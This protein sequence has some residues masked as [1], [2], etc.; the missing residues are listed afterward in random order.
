M[1]EKEGRTIDDLYWSG[2]TK[3][4]ETNLEKVESSNI[5]EKN[6]EHIKNFCIGLLSKC[7]NNNKKPTSKKRAAKLIIQLLTI[8]EILKEDLNELNIAHLERLMYEINSNDKW[9]NATKCDYR[10]AIKQFLYWYENYDDRFLSQDVVT[11]EQCR[12]MYKFIRENICLSYEKEIIDPEQII[13]KEDEILLIEKGCKTIQ[14]KAIITTLLETGARTSDLLLTNISGFK[15][16]DRGIG[17]LKLGHGKTGSREVDILTCVPYIIEFLKYH[18]DKDNPE[19]PLFYFEELKT[20]KTKFMNHSRLKITI[21]RIF[22]RAGLE[23]RHNVHWTRHSCITLNEL[24]NDLPRSVRNRIY[25]WS[26]K[27]RMFEQYIHIGRNE[28]R[29]AWEKAKNIPS[30]NEEKKEKMIMCI[31]Q[32]YI[33]SRNS[34]CPHCA[35]PT[36]LE[37]LKEEKK[38]SEDFQTEINK[39]L[40]I[41][42]SN[43]E[44][45]K[46][47]LE[48]IKFAIGLM[49][50]PKQLKEFEESIKGK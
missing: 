3:A 31:C 20:K 44:I 50:K 35:R 2:R 18:K 7:N 34:Y 4:Y 49:N 33:S 16:D 15:V 43:N 45:K 23:K 11:R 48:V 42:P 47:Y 39:L 26:D 1:K 24:N 21:E 32:R 13:T 37:V 10:R 29:K 28:E 12:R 8:C 40:E 17:C 36:S 19:S 30:V 9:S 41:N 22:K 14:E 38:R 5:S 25:G 27:S 6:K 46:E